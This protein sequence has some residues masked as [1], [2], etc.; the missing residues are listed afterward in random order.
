M[1]WTVASTPGMNLLPSNPLA[2]VPMQ[3]LDILSPVAPS[4][5]LVTSPFQ[6]VCSSYSTRLLHDEHHEAY[7]SRSLTHLQLLYPRHSASPR[8][9]QLCAHELTNLSCTQQS[10]TYPCCPSI[11]PCWHLWTELT[12][13]PIKAWKEESY[14][15]WLLEERKHRKGKRKERFSGS[16]RVR[17]GWLSGKEKERKGGFFFCCRKGKQKGARLVFLF[18]KIGREQRGK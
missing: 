17:K 2:Q 8:A 16:S 9:S 13:S 11:H 18:G 6:Q 15:G 10:A 1:T 4:Q 14:R 12:L 7:C 5:C 3:K